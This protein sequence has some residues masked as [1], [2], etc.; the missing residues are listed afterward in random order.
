MFQYRAS[1]DGGWAGSL[2]AA[3]GA[4]AATGALQA[5]I[6]PRTTIL[7]LLFVTAFAWSAAVLA[8]TLAARLRLIP[9]DVSRPFAL[10]NA[11]TT[12]TIVLGYAVGQV[13]VV[14]IFLDKKTTGS[15]KRVVRL[16]IQEVSR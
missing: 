9:C 16:L 5:A 12:F 7:L 14:S 1:T 15:F 13:N 10:R 6:L 4:L 8:L 11:I 2:G 3:L